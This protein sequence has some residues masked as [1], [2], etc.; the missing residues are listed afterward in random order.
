MKQWACLAVGLLG[1]QLGQLGY[2][3]EPGTKGLALKSALASEAKC[4]RC[5][6]EMEAKPILSIYQ[7]RHGV[8][9]D[10]RAPV[11]QDC[12]GESEAHVNTPPK[13]QTFPLTDTRFLGQH[14][15]SRRNSLATGQS[16]TGSCLSCHQ[17]NTARHWQ[18]S[19]HERQDLACHDCHTIHAP[20]DPILVRKN[21]PK[22]CLACHPTERMQLHLP[23][24]HPVMNGKM[25]C[26]DCHNPHGSTGPKLLQQENIQ[27]TC[28]H[29]HPDKRGP[30]LWEHAPVTEDCTACHAPHGA[31]TRP[32]LKMRSP[33]LCQQ[34]HSASKHPATAYSSNSGLNVGILASIN[35]TSQL[36][37]RGCNNCHSQ[38]HGSN[39]P[40]GARLL[41]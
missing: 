36:A 13:A 24:A 16:P 14:D 3:A 41:R 38:V 27:A 20:Q 28:L 11:C 35:N 8:K 34:C 21:Q 33:W 5:H 2:C 19:T 1:L 40:G 26:S 4:T 10:A 29:C 30:F 37:L 12:H 39:H 18:G 6:D 7:T 31:T 15:K 22:A 32:L 9:A 17:R 25:V 23:S